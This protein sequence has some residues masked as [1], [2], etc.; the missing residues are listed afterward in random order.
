MCVRVCVHACVCD[1]TPKTCITLSLPS[2]INGTIVGFPHAQP[3]DE[4]LLTAA[5]DILVP[6]AGEQQITADIARNLQAKVQ[7]YNEQAIS[8]SLA[9][10]THYIMTGHRRCHNTVPVCVGVLGAPLWRLYIAPGS[11]IGMFNPL[12]TVRNS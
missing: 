4:N 7:R 12:P 3:T 9:A 5:C 6:A 2:Q 10:V 1:T 11:S 8:L